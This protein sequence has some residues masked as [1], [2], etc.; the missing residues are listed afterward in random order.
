MPTKILLVLSLFFLFL[1]KEKIQAQQPTASVTTHKWKTIPAKKSIK[2]LR[3]YWSYYKESDEWE[4][5]D[6]IAYCLKG[7]EACGVQQHDSSCFDFYSELGYLYISL[8]SLEKSLFYLNTGL[9]YCYDYRAKTIMY[10][11]FGIVYH[12]ANDYSTAI[13]Y[14]LRSFHAAKKHTE[15]VSY[16]VLGNLSEVY[17]SME[18]WDNVIKYT[19]EDL[20]VAEKMDDEVYKYYSNIFNYAR[21]IDVFSIMGRVDST[22]YYI[23]KGETFVPKLDRQKN[24]HRDAIYQLNTRIVQHYLRVGELAKAKKYVEETKKIVSDYLRGGLNLLE[25]KYAFASGDGATCLEILGNINI[26]EETFDT[27]EEILKLKVD[28]YKSVG[29]YKNALNASEALQVVRAKKTDDLRLKNTALANAKYE[30][31]R[32]HEKIKRLQQER[33]LQQ[34]RTVLLWVVLVSLLSFLLAAVWLIR[35]NRKKTRLLEIDLENKK[36]IEEQAAELQRQADILRKNDAMKSHFFANIAHEL[37]TPLTLITAPLQHILQNHPI[38][39]AT[40]TEA[41]VAYKNASQ[42]KQLVNQILDLSKNE[43][44]RLAVNRQYFSLAM[45][46]EELAKE[47][48]AFAKYQKITFHTPM[49]PNDL[50]LNS[51]ADKIFIILKNLLSNAFKFTPSGGMVRFEYTQEGDKI[52]LSVADNGRGIHPEDMPHLFERYFQTK[53]IDAPMEGGTG[54][55]LAIAKEYALL[56]EG[57]ITAES[58]LGL[59]STFKLL[60]PKTQVEIASTPLNVAQIPHSEAVPIILHNT[61]SPSATEK[62]LVVEDN[63]DICRYLQ[64]VLQEDYHL[65]FAHNGQEALIFLQTQTADLVLTDLMMPVMNGFE[66]IKILKNHPTHQQL[67]ILMLTAR[68]ELTDKIQALTIGVDDYLVKP[69]DEAELKAT[70]QRLFNNLYQRRAYI[71]EGEEVAAKTAVAIE[72]EALP[73]MGMEDKA[74]LENLQNTVK[75]NLSNSNFT[76]TQLS[77]LVTMSASQLNRRLKLLVGLTAK[78][79]LTDFRFHT[80]KK[81]LEQKQYNTVK[82]VAY[83]VG[84]KDEKYFARQFKQRFG[85]YP[86]E[87]LE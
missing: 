30:S 50:W 59:G 78:E 7:C 72:T 18:D 54:L 42:L 53:Q 14:Y 6:R 51:D 33:D 19:H 75:E 66:L 56:L 22:N 65:A 20:K 21:L 17:F 12:D 32:K 13:D 64:T 16:F 5:D 74:W 34:T 62:I 28:Y 9:P 70:L 71:A 84:F 69:F 41:Q 76:T 11:Y 10:N 31:V 83:A 80:A 2:A 36:I 49:L 67:P 4:M 86:S 39:K 57:D 87:Y 47:F 40:R 8:D 24:D 27:Q 29:D 81:M 37:R 85:K 38:S 61:L 77:D 44:E 52:V 25:A 68:A 15:D 63:L 73:S 60:L 35:Q 46:V 55:G 43:F 1:Q 45:L 82:T 23:A 58:R 3:K 79:F 48:S 26:E